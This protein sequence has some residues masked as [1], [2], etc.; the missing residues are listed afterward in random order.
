MSTPIVPSGFAVPY[1][2][3]THVAIST[4]TAEPYVSITTVRPSFE[5]IS[6]PYVPRSYVFYDGCTSG[7]RYN[8]TGQ[9]FPR[10]LSS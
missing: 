1:V 9:L 3:N 7:V 10:G 2:S 6:P 4:V 5:S 8:L